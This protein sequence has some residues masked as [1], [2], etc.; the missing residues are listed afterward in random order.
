MSWELAAVAFIADGAFSR[1]L[2]RSVITAPIAFVTLGVGAGAVLDATGLG[3]RGQ[4]IR[5]LAEVQAE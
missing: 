2:D 4:T 3:F 5:I 1:F